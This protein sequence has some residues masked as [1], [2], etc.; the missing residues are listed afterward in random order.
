MIKELLKTFSLIKK[1]PF[2]S[3]ITKGFI[4][5]IGMDETGKLINLNQ[6]LSDISKYLES[7]S[8]ENPTT[9]ISKLSEKY[10]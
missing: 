6:K 2:L 10:N 1:V 4:H 9:N 7:I 8:V 5:F 3:K